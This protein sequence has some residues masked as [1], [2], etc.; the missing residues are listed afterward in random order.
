MKVVEVV[1]VEI[2]QLIVTLNVIFTHIV[3]FFAFIFLVLFFFFSLI[4]VVERLVIAFDNTTLALLVKPFSPTPSLLPTPELTQLLVI[5]NFLIELV[6]Y[7]S[8]NHGL[9]LSDW[10]LCGIPFGCWGGITRVSDH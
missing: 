1:I 6:E 8:H 7:F 3:V 2:V 4:V 9:P 10:I 5:Q